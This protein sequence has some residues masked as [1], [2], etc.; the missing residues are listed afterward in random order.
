MDGVTPANVSSVRWK[1]SNSGQPGQIVPLCSLHTVTTAVEL[2][3]LVAH[4]HMS[5]YST[6]RQMMI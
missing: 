2:F 1:E 5:I 4:R 6:Y 3:N